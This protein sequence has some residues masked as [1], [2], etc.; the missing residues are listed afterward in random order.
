[1]T[2]PDSILSKI[3]K[4]QALTTDRGA[5]PEEAATAAAKA[6]ALLFEHNLSQCD[7]DTK[8]QAG[9]DPYGKVETTL[10]G[11]NRNTVTWRRTLLYTIAKHNFCTAITLPN[12][13][14]M[15]VIGKR[16]NVE[17]VLY[18]NH[19]LV[20]EIER[21]AVEAGRTVLSNRAAYMVSFC[22]GAVSTIH[23]RLQ[24]QQQAS[25][26]QATT[27]SGTGNDA[28]A[29]SNA[30]ALRTLS[31]ELN[32]AVCHFYPSGLRTSTVRSRVGSMDGYR[33]GQQ[34]GA[35]IS[36]HRGVGSRSAAGYLN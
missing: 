9:P 3:K 33:S 31:E 14:K 28:R 1:M 5:T 22:R 8:E 6:Q 13:T 34:A 32:K 21:L 11:A 27:Y 12:Q 20:R 26:Q 16:S 35:G 15:I 24:E 19:I 30:V 25:T 7:V 4:L 10:E 36:M 17:T 29:N 2:T 18:L 23:K